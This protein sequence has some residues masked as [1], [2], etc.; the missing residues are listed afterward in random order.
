[1]DV[2]NNIYTFVLFLDTVLN[3]PKIMYMLSSIACNFGVNRSEIM[4]CSSSSHILRII[5]SLVAIAVDVIFCLK[6]Y[7]WNQDSNIYSSYF[8]AQQPKRKDI[9]GYFLEYFAPAIL[10]FDYK[11][12][13]FTPFTFY[14]IKFKGKARLILLIVLFL[15]SL[16][17]VY[18]NITKI[19]YYK[20]NAN[21][22][23]QLLMAC[24]LASYIVGV[25]HII[26]KN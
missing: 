5:L 3:F 8:L 14:L 11:V 1:V 7:L 4:E 26:Y 23:T 24:A 6:N 12:F 9:L 19:V 20:R 16:K 2:L 25:I 15:V 17:L 13:F 21:I 10:V 18:N 22:L